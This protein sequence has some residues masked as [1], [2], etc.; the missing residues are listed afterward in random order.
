MVHSGDLHLKCGPRFPVR[1]ASLCSIPVH[2]AAG[3]MRTP[4][5]SLL[6]LSAASASLAAVVPRWQHA[7]SCSDLWDAAPKMLANLEVYVAEDIPGESYIHALMSIPFCAPSLRNEP[8]MS[9]SS[10]LLTRYV[11]LDSR[12]QL[13]YAVCDGV[14]PFARSRHAGR[15]PLWSVHPHE[16]HVRCSRS[17]LRELLRLTWSYHMMQ[18]QG[19]VRS[20]AAGRLERPLRRRRQRRRR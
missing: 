16:Q 3:A 17:A 2:T 1:A 14:V 8:S 9:H 4:T 10:T 6:A 12:Y 18:L 11:T 15:L 5:V 20:L 13:H 19:S 7:L